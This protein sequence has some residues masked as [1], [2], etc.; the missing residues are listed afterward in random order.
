[1]GKQFFVREVPLYAE[2]A[3]PH[4]LRLFFCSSWC[5]CPLPPSPSCSCPPAF[6]SA[7][8]PP[9][10]TSASGALSFRTRSA[11]TLLK[12][13]IPVAATRYSMSFAWDLLLNSQTRRGML[14]CG[15]SAQDT[16]FAEPCAGW[17]LQRGRFRGAALLGS[18]HAFGPLLDH[19]VLA[20]NVGSSQLM[21]A[22]RAQTLGGIMWHHFS[23]VGAV[24]TRLTWLRLA[25]SSLISARSRLVLHRVT[26]SIHAGVPPVF[27]KLCLCMQQCR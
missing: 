1:M 21:P 6:P 3:R 20:Q 5:A 18:M 23:C 27:A 26:V 16:T 19:P 7:T 8:A 4:A 15:V 9:W 10:G 14:S 17:W 2:V 13:R 11:S 12:A 25:A 22:H 24:R